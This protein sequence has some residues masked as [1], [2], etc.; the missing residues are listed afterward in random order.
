MESRCQRTFH[1]EATSRRLLLGSVA[2]GGHGP[3]LIGVRGTEH[4]RQGR[5]LRCRFG[6]TLGLTLGM[7]GGRMARVPIRTSRSYTTSRPINSSFDYMSRLRVPPAFQLTPEG[8][9]AVVLDR[10]D[11][12]VGRLRQVWR[13]SKGARSRCR[14]PPTRPP[15]A[16]MRRQIHF[17]QPG[18]GK[19]SNTYLGI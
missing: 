3:I 14:I 5:H 8:L 1:R 19:P 4:Q 18:P 11:T 13:L 7:M 16:Q 17:A 15:C 2:V 6:L 12:R 10:Y 9:P